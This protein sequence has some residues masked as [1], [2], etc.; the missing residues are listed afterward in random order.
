MV[1][2]TGFNQTIS[3]GS[4]TTLFTA[5]ASTTLKGVEFVPVPEPSTL[6]LA[7][8]GVALAGLVAWKRRQTFTAVQAV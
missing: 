4:P 6:G 3:L 5:A 8:V 7:G 2:S 1:D